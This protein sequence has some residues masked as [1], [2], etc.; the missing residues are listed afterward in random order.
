MKA[1]ACPDCDLL[2]VLG[3]QSGGEKARCLRC[4]GV[5]TGHGAHSYETSLALA[6]AATITLILANTPPLMQMSELRQESST[7]VVGSAVVMWLPGSEAT[8]NL[9][10][11][12]SLAATGFL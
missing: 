1:V 11:I 4:G 8:V 7:T 6:I 5:L 10:S 12:F 9:R 3:P 2:H